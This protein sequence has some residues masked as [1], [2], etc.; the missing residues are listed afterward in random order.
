VAN[1]IILMGRLGAKPEMRRV[2]SNNTPVVEVSVATSAFSKG[3][4]STDWHNVT[5]WD[6]QAELICTQDKGDMVYIEGSLKH[7]EFTDK[8]GNRRRKSYVRAF[9]FEFCGSRK[10]SGPPTGQTGP[11]SSP[12]K[13][14]DIQW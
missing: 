5:L 2:G 6:K 1:T 13:D 7:D 8:E 11:S 10:Q 3:E 4:K 12:Y 14:D 9:R